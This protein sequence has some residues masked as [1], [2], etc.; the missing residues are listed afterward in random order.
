[1]KQLLGEDPTAD[2]LSAALAASM[3][4]AY[5]VVMKED[6]YFTLIHHLTMLDVELRPQDPI[7]GRLVA[8]EADV[9]YDVFP[10]RLVVLDAR[11]RDMFKVLRPVLGSL[12]TVN[13]AYA[14]AGPGDRK[15]LG[16]RLPEDG[17]GDNPA[18]TTRLIPI[19]MAWGA[20]FLDSPTFG[21]AVRRMH[22]LLDAIPRL[23]QIQFAPILDSLLL[24]C[25]GD[26][27]D[28]RDSYSFLS[29]EWDP[30]PFDQRMKTWMQERWSEITANNDDDVSD[31]EG[32]VDS[33]DDRKLPARPAWRP[34]SPQN[35]PL[36]SRVRRHPARWDPAQSESGE[37]QRRQRPSRKEKLG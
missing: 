4:R 27:L 12:N 19:P 23:E 15:F 26:R 5:L 11:P 10:P 3:R 29:S 8:F 9:L 13:G 2:K 35:P 28:E 20:Y 21:V 32:A 7:K 22:R 30:V 16:V 33:D 6:R 14:Q 18:A 17:G 31:G 34:A 24:A 37:L 25:Y 1:M 36:P